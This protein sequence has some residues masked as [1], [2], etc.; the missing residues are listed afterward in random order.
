[1]YPYIRGIEAASDG[2]RLLVDWFEVDPGADRSIMPVLHDQMIVSGIAPAD[3]RQADIDAVLVER[4]AA[5]VA[6]REAATALK[7]SV[8]AMVGTVR[9][10]G[11]DG[12]SSVSR[13]KAEK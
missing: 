6:E 3:L 10:I 13:G 12:R 2:S 7:P 11:A 5:L 9:S 8:L 1:M 4:E